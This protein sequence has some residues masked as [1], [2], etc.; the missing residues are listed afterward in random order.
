MM[1]EKGHLVVCLTPYPDLVTVSWLKWVNRL[2]QS[3]RAWQRWLLAQRVY[4]ELES[5]QPKTVVQPMYTSVS[6][7]ADVVFWG[8]EEQ[9][10]NRSVEGEGEVGNGDKESNVEGA[11]YSLAVEM[12]AARL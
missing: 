12:S 9:R 6:G 2:Y 3:Y 5:D 10:R 4:H 11:K 8:Q 1:M 7:L